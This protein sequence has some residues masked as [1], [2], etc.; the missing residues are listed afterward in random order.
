VSVTEVRLGIKLQGDC[1][2]TQC[3]GYAQSLLHQLSSGNY[4]LMSVLEIPRDV[5]DWRAEHRTAR[6]RVN[7]AQGRGYR[8][9]NLNRTGGEDWD[10]I[11]RSTPVRQGRPMSAGY[12]NPSEFSRLPDYPCPVHATR[13][14][15][16]EDRDGNLVAYLVILRAGDLALVS[17]ILGHDAYLSDEIMSLLFQHALGRETHTPGLMVYNRHDSGGLGLRGWKEWHGFEEREV[18]WLP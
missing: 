15:G 6:K 10:A 2:N 14:T 5:E 7:R 9:V 18:E 13:V 17:Q 16:V 1:T 12:M 11:N 4:D 3:L 8:A